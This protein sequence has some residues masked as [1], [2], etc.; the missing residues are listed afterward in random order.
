M[1]HQMQELLDLRLK[2]QCFALLGR[3]LVHISHVLIWCLLQ[4]L[5]KARPHGHRLIL[6]P[7]A[8]GAFFQ[9]L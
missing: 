5:K 8:E 4:A 3:R 2:S 7:E 6:Q 9:G 1:D